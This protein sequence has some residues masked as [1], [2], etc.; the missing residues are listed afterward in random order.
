MTIVPVTGPEDVPGVEPEVV[1]EPLLDPELG[2][3]ELVPPHPTDTIP[4]IRTRTML[5]QAP[6]RKSAFLKALLRANTRTKLAGNNASRGRAAD[7]G[8]RRLLDV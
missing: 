1:P 8:L 3:A 4:M 6:W 2:V 5:N 7:S